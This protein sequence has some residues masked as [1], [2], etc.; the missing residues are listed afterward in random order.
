MKKETWLLHIDPT[1]DKTNAQIK[2]SLREHLASKCP[3]CKARQVTYK[4]N[5]SRNARDGIMRD[6][7]LVRVK[8]G[9]GKTYWE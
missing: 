4:A 9:L 6:L 8:S 2:Q 7:G 5:K 3:D 1:K